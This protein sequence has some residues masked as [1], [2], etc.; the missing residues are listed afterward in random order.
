MKRVDSL[1]NSRKPVSPL[2]SWS[3]KQVPEQ[4]VRE[5]DSL[6]NSRYLGLSYPPSRKIREGSI[7]F[8]ERRSSLQETKR[9]E[10]FLEDPHSRASQE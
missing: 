8:S 5:G 2:L 10:P 7:R 1:V 4:L 3:P 6:K 9:S